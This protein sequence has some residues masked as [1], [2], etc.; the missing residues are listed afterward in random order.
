[1]IKLFLIFILASSYNCQDTYT[2]SRELL[3]N[4]PDCWEEI[5]QAKSIVRY[6]PPKELEAKVPELYR[7]L[8]KVKYSEFDE[9][10]GRTREM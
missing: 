9:L 1:M 8:D 10:L 5:S 2:L 3:C 6:A 4:D 7:A